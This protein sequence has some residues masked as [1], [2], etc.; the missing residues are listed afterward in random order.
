MGGAAGTS[1]SIGALS[2]QP[3]GT[4]VILA[5]T[6][7]TNDML[8]SYYGAGILRSTDGGNTWTLVTSTTDVASNLGTSDYTFA[9]EGF[10]SIAWSTI[11][12][13]LVVAAVSQAYGGT[14]RN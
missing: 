6:G 2:V 5:G 14:V 8:D 3:G 12:S 9:G 11:N 7:D 4:G 1:I 10:S 13:Q